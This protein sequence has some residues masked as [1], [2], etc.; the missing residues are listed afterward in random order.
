MKFIVLSP[1]FFALSSAIRL[2]GAKDSQEALCV[3]ENQVQL[4][5]LQTEISHII[6]HFAHEVSYLER[7]PAFSS[8][9]A[10][11]DKLFSNMPRS[12]GEGRINETLRQ[13]R[14]VCSLKL[15]TPASGLPVDVHRDINSLCDGLI[16]SLERYTLVRESQ[17]A[18]NLFLLATRAKLE[19]NNLGLQ[20]FA[21]LE[22]QASSAYTEYHTLMDSAND[23][24]AVCNLMRKY[25][26]F[27]TMV[28][29]GEGE[30]NSWSAR[31]NA[32]LVML[33]FRSLDHL[34]E[35][36][37]NSHVDVAECH[38][39]IKHDFSTLAAY[40]SLMA[41]PRCEELA[42]AIEEAD[43]VVARILD[44]KK[45]LSE[46]AESVVR[47][48]AA[49]IAD[50]DYDNALI[51]ADL[52]AE[53]GKELKQVLIDEVSAKMDK[54]AYAQ[55]RVGDSGEKL[56]KNIP[57]FYN[58]V[59]TEDVIAPNRPIA[60]PIQAKAAKATQN[61]GN[62]SD[63]ETLVR[64]PTGE[65]DLSVDEESGDADEGSQV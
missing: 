21:P 64:A 33:R 23:H 29:S 61:V 48:M 24:V 55:R 60:T 58:R 50:N 14:L 44:L 41:E 31:S 26:M 36:F 49:F 62:S 42:H 34:R 3:A 9:R 45:S 63:S 25:N 32:A 59:A 6:Q 65:A 43:P 30:P 57:G 4:E 7:A 47:M 46:R 18:A 2:R 5:R 1:A 22:R 53:D 35:R 40:R 54:T 52:N 56:W 51:F 19:P 11:L 12:V 16:Q 28:A 39:R 13:V 27:T 37:G 38:G 8:P 15:E 20:R 17:K 10:E